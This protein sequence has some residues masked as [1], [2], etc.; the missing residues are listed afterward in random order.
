M[1]T[2][3]SNR[4]PFQPVTPNYQQPKVTPKSKTVRTFESATRAKGEIKPPITRERTTPVFRKRE[5]KEEAPGQFK[6]IEPVT[7]VARAQGIAVE[8][9]APPSP[10]REFRLIPAEK[11]VGPLVGGLRHGEGTLVDESGDTF[12]GP[13]V[14][15]KRHGFFKV[16]F[17]NGDTFEGEFVNDVN[18]E[19]TLYRSNGDVLKSTHLKGGGVQ[20]YI[21]FANKDTL[22]A[23]Y[24][25]GKGIG[26]L[27]YANGD[28]YAGEF[29]GE[30]PQGGGTLTYA[31]K[32]IYVGVFH[33][34]K[35]QGCGTLYFANGD[36]YEGTFSAGKI[37]GQGNFTYSNGC[38][39][40][41]GMLEG[42]PHGK[43]GT[44]NLKSK[45][46]IES[47]DFLR[48]PPCNYSV[49]KTYIG[50]FLEGRF[51]C[52][53]GLIDYKNGDLYFGECLNEMPHGE[54]RL[55]MNDGS[56]YEGQFWEGKKHGQ[57]KL[58]RPGQ[59][60]IEGNF[61][62]DLFD[63]SSASNDCEIWE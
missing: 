45:D 1:S 2:Q 18:K 34:G 23:I 27:V 32:N 62:N 26:T 8:Q 12:V 54:G 60:T 55:T 17:A 14:K 24:V 28:R 5:R 35:P 15:G 50:E 36:I 19:G 3:P 59:P 20:L 47:C 53:E 31:D 39:Y 63:V 7:K 9:E 61:I 25:D 56:R 40:R 46:N 38:S 58:T 52:K 21:L 41:G 51:T 44:L 33:L 43:E 37:T 11:Y 10:L 30:L 49:G 48:W 6:E 13:F 29:F 42:K 16:H 4:K 22:D 57:G